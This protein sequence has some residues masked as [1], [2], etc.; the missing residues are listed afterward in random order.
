MPVMVVERLATEVPAGAP[1]MTSVPRRDSKV[2][3]LYF[4]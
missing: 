2:L 4:L 1:K 3:K